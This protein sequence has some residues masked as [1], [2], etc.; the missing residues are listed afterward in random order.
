MANEQAINVTEAD[1]Q[2]AA[3][4]VEAFYQ[5]LPPSEQVVIGWLLQR[6]AESEDIRGYDFAP[7]RSGHVREA[8]M[9]GLGLSIAR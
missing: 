6:A 7:V 1:I 4:K 3:Q 2:S 9:D 8:I 5:G